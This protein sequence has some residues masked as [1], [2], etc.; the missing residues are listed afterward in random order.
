MVMPVMLALQGVS[1]ILRS[2][3]ILRRS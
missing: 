2:L 3:L 1:M